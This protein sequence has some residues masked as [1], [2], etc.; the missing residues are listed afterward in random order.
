MGDE[1]VHTFLKSI[2]VKE[3]II[4]RLEFELTYF[5]ASVQLF[6]QYTM[7]TGSCETLQTIILRQAMLA[8][9]V[10]GCRIHRLYLCRAEDS[11]SEGPGYDTK[12]SDGQA[13]VMLQLWGM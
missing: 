6:S 13:P 11:P 2:S 1:G 12:Q 5:D 10:W 7:D 9:L 3:N 4:A 8:K